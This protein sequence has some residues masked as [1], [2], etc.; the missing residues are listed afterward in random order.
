MAD[1]D[2]EFKEFVVLFMRNDRQNIQHIIAARMV[3]SLGGMAR[4]NRDVIIIHIKA[5][6]GLVR[7]MVLQSHHIIANKMPKC[8][9]DR[10]IKCSRPVFLN[11]M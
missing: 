4:M 10:L 3:G 1:S 5:R 2:S 8:I 9:P 7:P 6:A 11:A